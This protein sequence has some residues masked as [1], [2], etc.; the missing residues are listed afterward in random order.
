MISED[1]RD[2]VMDAF[3]DVST[4]ADDCD[5]WVHIKKEVMKLL[6]SKM[7]KVFSRRDSKTKNHILNNFETEMINYYE[8][9]TGIRL[10]LRSLDERR[11]IFGHLSR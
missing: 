9:L 8:G 4:Y 6:P 2:R 7:R 11:K 1:V 3:L 10:V 5:D